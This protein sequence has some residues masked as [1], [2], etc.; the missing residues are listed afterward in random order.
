MKSGINMTENSDVVE[1]LKDFH[2]KRARKLYPIGPFLASYS[3]MSLTGLTIRNIRS[4]AV[5]RLFNPSGTTV[6]S[7]TQILST[8]L[9]GHHQSIL[10]SYTGFK[11]FT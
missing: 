2:R 11:I 7:K 1:N 9:L 3:R 5:P 4:G 10:L 6:S 8:L